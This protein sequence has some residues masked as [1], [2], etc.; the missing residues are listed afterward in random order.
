[1]KW[2]ADILN[3][4]EGRTPLD[5]ADGRI[6]NIDRMR[7]GSITRAKRPRRPGGAVYR[8]LPDDDWVTIFTP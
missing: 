3:R 4:L 5:T 2:L 1:M 7:D 8:E 6:V